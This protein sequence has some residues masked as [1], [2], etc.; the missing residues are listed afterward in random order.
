MSSDRRWFR[1][2][3]DALADLLVA[4]QKEADDLWLRWSNMQR[5]IVLT[6][7]EMKRPAD[8]GP[9]D[10]DPVVSPAASSSTAEFDPQTM[11][12][13][14]HAPKRAKLALVRHASTQT[15]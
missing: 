15:D 2:R 12:A 7:N 11:F 3:P 6:Q 9:Y 8:E 10:D 14:R 4:Q 5:E 13:P 1:A